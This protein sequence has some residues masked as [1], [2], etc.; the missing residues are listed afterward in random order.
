MVWA[1]GKQLHNGRYTIQKVLGHGRFG[2]TYL[3]KDKVGDTVVIKTLN[4][5]SLNRPDFKRLQQVF[6]QEA[7]KLARCRHRYIV[8]AELPFQE[9]ELW[10]IAM[11]YID[12]V[13]LAS[14]AQ[15]IL[16]EEE[17]LRYIQ[18]VGE[19]LIEV[20]HNGLLH[21]DIRPGNIM[22]RVRQG[23][24]EAVLIDFGLAQEF[25]HDLTM[26]RT[27]EVAEG[28]AP[29]E[30]YSRQAKRGAYTDIYSLGATL[31]VL[32]TGKLPVSAMVRKA[33]QSRLISLFSKTRLIPPKDIN[34][35]ISIHVN[36]AILWAMELEAE[37]R[38]QSIQEWLDL[39]GLKNN[40]PASTIIS[41]SPSTHE[42]ERNFKK[43]TL[44]WAAITAVGT[45]IGGIATWMNLPNSNSPPTSNPPNTNKQ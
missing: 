28:F 41:N 1:P 14:L 21:Q 43:W 29:L 12:G 4:D 19:A 17:A 11:E 3:A 15:P 36:R 35:K 13:D 16:P 5:A 2:I 18:Q 26:T 38:P 22:L 39:L 37:H 31:Y 6:V 8:R 10:C 30:L 27:E 34:S 7:V 20:H 42:R 25:D 23:E 44:V 45:L 33:S 9:D 24:A 32:L 40:N